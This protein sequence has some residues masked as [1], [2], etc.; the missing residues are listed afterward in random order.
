MT[1]IKNKYY[2]ADLL[3][4]CL[5]FII[6]FWTVPLSIFQL[7]KTRRRF[8]AVLISVFFALT[9]SLLAPTGD[10]YRI[11]IIYF[12]FQDTSF[13]SLLTF[14]STKPDFMFYLILYIFAQAGLSVRIIIFALIFSFFQVSFDLLLKQKRQISIL[15]VLLFI[16]QFDFLLQGLFVRFPLAMLFVIYAFLNSMDGK[17]HAWILLVLA[18]MIHFAAL[19]TIPLYFLS[20]VKFKKLNLFLLLSLFI[21]PF[22]SLM[23]IFI[24]GQLLQ[25]L[26]ETPLKTKIDDYFLGYWA[27]E[28]FEERT[29]KALFQFYFE[30]VFYVFILLYFLFT[31]DQSTY[32]RHAI[33]F[34][35]LINILFSF[36][37]LFSRYALLPV[38]FGL[39]TILQER[40]TSGISY[41]IKV[42]LAI[43]IPI[44]F[45]IRIVAQQKNIRVGY[46]PEVIYTNIIGLSLKSY[47][48]DW[49]IKNIDK[50]T[51]LP[52]T[53]ESL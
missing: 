1:L 38:F 47:D 41:F 9:A 35:I 39:Y 40:R 36:P 10:L 26:P 45:T 31:K 27:L 46:I 50:E 32:R 24:T 43:I 52:K 48:K 33:P 5:F 34:L 53:V 18:S 8:Y 29:W 12:D 44:V 22:G 15:V 13:E 25:Y 4:G 7:F 23:L 16:L 3:L 19:I 37:N 49:I 28:Y 30:R 6:P 17:K 42:S 11:Y 14:L 21:I 51:A 2:T 20:K